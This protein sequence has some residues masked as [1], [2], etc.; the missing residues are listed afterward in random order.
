M[1]SVDPV[2]YTNDV[3]ADL[4]GNLGRAWKLDAAAIGCREAGQPPAE[5]TVAGWIIYAPY[6][7]P[8]WHSYLLSAVSLRDCPGARPAKIYLPGATHEVLLYALN[9][10]HRTSINDFPHPLIPTNFHGQWIAENDEAAAR[11][12]D[13]TVRMVCEGQL[14]PDTDYTRYWIHRFSASNIKGDPKRAGETRIIFGG[15]ELVIPP[16]PGPQDLH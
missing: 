13:E 16:K 10:E 9:P 1:N 3:P 4:T 8:V 6:A 5:L 11:Y 14:N 7:H 2:I 12:I 15:T